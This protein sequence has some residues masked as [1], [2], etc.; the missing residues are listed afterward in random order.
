MSPTAARRRLGAVLREFRERAGLTLDDAG[1]PLQRSAATISRLENGKVKPRLIDVGA[2]ID[3]FDETTPGVS[4]DERAL[5]LGLAADSR[6]ETWFSPFRDVLAGTMV[7]EHGRRYMEFETDA[8]TIQNYEP[9]LVPGLL[10]TPTYTEQIAARFYPDH[11][12]EQ[13]R[14]FVEFR[15]ARQNVLTRKPSPLKLHAVLGEQVLRRAVGDV[16]VMRTQLKAL[17]HNVRNGLPN[18]TIQVA[19][20]AL[21]TR[22]TIGGAFVVMS[23]ADAQDD[24]LVY[25]EGRSGADYLY[26]EGELATYRGYFTE[27]ADLALDQEGSLA[28]I[29]EA[30]KELA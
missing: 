9:D 1:K 26:G 16:E 17:A 21:L 19:P 7:S 27:L 29:E 12:I 8:D 2:L 13:R 6:R 28:A 25:L 23:F 4:D 14:R 15:S 11:E 22:A 18:V 30:L 10:Q 5:V 24:D 3:L 20:A